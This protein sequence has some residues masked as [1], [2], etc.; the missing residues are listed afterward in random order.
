M[1]ILNWFHLFVCFHVLRMI[2]FYKDEALCTVEGFLECMFMSH[3]GYAHKCAWNTVEPRYCN[4]CS[5]NVTNRVL[6]LAITCF[7]LMQFL[8][9]SLVLLLSL[10]AFMAAWH[11]A[12]SSTGLRVK[13]WVP[14]ATYAVGPLYF[15]GPCENVATMIFQMEASLLL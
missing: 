2:R 9:L 15:H 3:P 14:L 12:C 10:Q 1:I 6:H 13:I 7:N 11:R 4:L 5:V 8:L